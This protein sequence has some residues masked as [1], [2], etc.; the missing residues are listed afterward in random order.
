MALGE[1]R[2]MR[3]F[4]AWLLESTPRIMALVLSFAE[5][6]SHTVIYPMDIHPS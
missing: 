1:T 6:G 3:P 2:I 5:G 4:H